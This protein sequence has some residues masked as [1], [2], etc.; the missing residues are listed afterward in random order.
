MALASNRNW[1]SAIGHIGEGEIERAA[2]EL[3]EARRL[4]GNGSPSS[5]AQAK[6]PDARNFAAPVIRALYE[7]TYTSMAQLQVSKPTLR[8]AR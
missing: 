4:S 5:I 2:A 7:A 1:A 8:S 6:A 3:A